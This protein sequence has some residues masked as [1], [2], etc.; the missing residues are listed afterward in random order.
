MRAIELADALQD[1]ERAEAERGEQHPD[2]EGQDRQPDQ[3]QARIAAE[4][5]LHVFAPLARY[6]RSEN[7]AAG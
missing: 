5:P 1:V 4:E 7:R 6:T 3:H 2:D